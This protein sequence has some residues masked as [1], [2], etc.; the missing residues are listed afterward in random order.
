M[1]IYPRKHFG[2]MTKNLGLDL[3]KPFNEKADFSWEG[4]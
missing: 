1:K 2:F 4:L 3:N